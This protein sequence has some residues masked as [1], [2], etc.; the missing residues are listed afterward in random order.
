M[1]GDLIEACPPPTRSG[2]Q[3]WNF[4]MGARAVRSVT[5][6]VLHLIRTTTTPLM[7]ATSCATY[8]DPSTN[9]ALGRPYNLDPPP[10]YS[11]GTSKT[12]AQVLTD[13]SVSH[14]GTMWLQ[15]SAVGWTHVRPVTITVDLGDV[16][17]IDRVT[18]HCAAGAA[19]VEWP[20]SIL[21]FASI[22][23]KSFSFLG[24]IV[25]LDAARGSV[26]PHG[27]Y[28]E[29]T[30]S[31]KLP[32][33]AAR[34]L[35]LIADPGDPYLF[36]DEIQVF[37]A[38]QPPARAGAY[39]IVDTAAEF[40]RT[41]SA[42]KA[43]EAIRSDAARIR[44]RLATLNLP[45]NRRHQFEAQA[46][47]AAE[48]AISTER[49]SLGPRPNFPI[50]PAHV[51]LYAALGSAEE[52]AGQPAL[53]AWP[54]NPWDPLLPEEIPHGAVPAR[55]IIGAMRGERRSG[56]VNIRNSTGQPQNLVLSATIDGISAQQLLLAPVAWTGTQQSGW[57]AAKILDATSRLTVPAGLTQQI[58]IT[59]DAGKAAPGVHSGVI[60]VRSSGSSVE[61][62][63]A[64]RVFSTQFPIH[65]NVLVEGW[66]Y[67]QDPGTNG[68]TT[69]NVDAV[70]PFLRSQGVNVAWATRAVFEFGHYDNAGH[71]S[72]PPSASTLDH[73]LARWPSAA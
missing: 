44:A 69:S 71:L 67:L 19:G 73:W 62:P 3:H 25:E 9:V 40:W 57:V 59:F 53:Q 38:D 8:A 26:P 36:V 27:H 18:W 39:D 17:T 2:E 24:D 20:V 70:A 32:A 72:V 33:A 5:A 12:G 63:V 35:R 42:T 64:L 21:A 1:I 4:K 51:A 43:K 29:Y 30:F 66:D 49:T 13:G 16:V 48:S 65:Q 54:A 15:S 11:G 46:S 37:R 52:E 61:V 22:D 10:N 47:T 41:H 7:L 55:V 31:A 50:G 45:E 60:R 34:Y 14:G 28:S 58:W 6:D 56:A 68:I 23:A